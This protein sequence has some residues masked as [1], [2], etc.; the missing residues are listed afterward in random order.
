MLRP[1]TPLSVLVFVAF[2]LLLLSVL[3]TPIIK[4]VKLGS[5]QGVDFGVFGFCQGSRCSGVTVGYNP[6]SQFNSRRKTDFSLPPSARTSLSSLL[7]VHP[8]AAFFTLVVLILSLASHLRSPSHSPRYF[9]ILMLLMLPAFLLSLLA[10]LVDILLFVP[11]L[12]WASWL[13]LAATILLAVGGV[14]TCVMRRALVGRKAH[15]KRI[16]ENAD[17]N[18]DSYYNQQSVSPPGPVGAEPTA[19]NGVGSSNPDKLPEF[20]TFD[21]S[22][23][24]VDRPGQEERIPLNPRTP[25]NA[26]RDE[27]P[28]NVRTVPSGPEDGPTSF[29]PPRGAGAAFSFGSGRAY[30]ETGG[31]QFQPSLP[32]PALAAV[33]GMRRNFSDPRLRDQQPNGAFILSNPPTPSSV[34]SRG[35]GGYGINGKGGYGRGGYVGPWRGPPPQAMYG[36]GRGMGPSGPM[37]PLGGQAFRR[38]GGPPPDY[39]RGGFINGGY[40]NGGYGRGGSYSRDQSP[41]GGYYG[42]REGPPSAPAYHNGAS[43]GP[44]PYGAGDRSPGPGSAGQMQRSPS[45]PPPMPAEG[46]LVGQAVEMDASTGS[47]SPSHTPF[48]RGH[49]RVGE[50]DLQSPTGLPQDAQTDPRLHEKA[51]LS[52]TSVYSSRPESYVPPRAGWAQ[53]NPD[54]IPSVDVSRTPPPGEAKTSP[55]ELPTTARSEEHPPNP[56]PTHARVASSDSYYED[57]DPRFDVTAHVPTTSTVDVPASLQPAYRQP[58]NAAYPVMENPHITMTGSNSYENIHDMARS[59]AQSDTSHYTSVSQRGVNPNWQPPSPQGGV[60]P[61]RQVQRP[62]RDMLLAGNSDFE[63]P[64]GPSRG[65]APGGNM[66]NPTGQGGVAMT[67]GSRYPTS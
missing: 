9:L 31:P 13:V 65:R 37:G 26:M 55:V 5:F 27:E 14:L 61:P 18:G 25:L 2:V 48:A 16:A 6:N 62:Q 53:E 39:S 38:G 22:Q 30:S 3:S 51:R 43:P 41:A 32:P 47:P 15:Q 10:F 12:Q 36:G 28:M 42:R 64:G 29:R 33:P 8:I 66:P 52:P 1:A 40:G 11:H 54:A 49:P 45:P 56:S 7:I 20:A 50:G 34:N 59:P 63:L 4:S 44:W 23:N 24:H 35:R 57:V 58:M 21:V 67:S 17:M 60:V 46:V 19:I